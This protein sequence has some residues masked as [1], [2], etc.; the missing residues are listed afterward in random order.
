MKKVIVTFILFFIF[1][2][3]FSVELYLFTEINRRDI[4]LEKQIFTS[5]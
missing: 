4:T 1:I 5:S 2:F 3:V